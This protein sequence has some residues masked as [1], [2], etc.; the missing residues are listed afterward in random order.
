MHLINDSIYLMEVDT[1]LVLRLL[2][3]LRDCSRH[4]ERGVREHA[5]DEVDVGIL[6]LAEQT[7]GE[8]RPSQAGERLE[9]ASPSITRHVRALQHAGRVSITPD[10]EDHRGYRI[11]LTDTGRSML[12]DFREN[13]VSRFAPVLHGWDPAELRALVDGMVRLNAAMDAARETLPAR[14]GSSWWRTPGREE[15]GAGDAA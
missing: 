6:V 2:G 14:R 5:L 9:V 4:V 1:T 11:A 13:L 7:G 3:A 8:L 15:A 12:D 10:R